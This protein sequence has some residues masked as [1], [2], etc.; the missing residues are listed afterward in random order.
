ML[1]MVLV[2]IYRNA[3]FISIHD[4][5][6]SASAALTEFMEGR[7]IERFGEDF[8]G[9]S[10]SIEERTRRFFAEEDSTYILGEADLSEVE[11]HIDAALRS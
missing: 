7:W 5:E 10:L 2:I 1:V 4:D 9:T 11:A 8:P 3:R 6:S